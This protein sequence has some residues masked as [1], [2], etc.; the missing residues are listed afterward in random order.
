VTTEED[1]SA[2]HLIPSALQVW[3]LGS[4]YCWQTPWQAIQQHK[5][6]SDC[7]SA[8]LASFHNSCSHACTHDMLDLVSSS[9][10]SRITVP[11]GKVPTAA[12]A[13]NA[14]PFQSL[15][16]S[17]LNQDLITC[18]YHV[19]R[20]ACPSAAAIHRMTPELA[21]ALQQ[22]KR[23]QALL[24]HGGHC[25]ASASVPSG[26]TQKLLP[27]HCHLYDQVY[28]RFLYGLPLGL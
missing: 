24:V 14:P 7:P 10:P 16:L 28:M 15:I 25:R 18:S 12:A 26:H 11:A 19:T 27:C 21:M 3:W 23:H 6:L 20:S 4:A 5:G 17:L 1:K 13:R 2:R 8:L 9:H 22:W